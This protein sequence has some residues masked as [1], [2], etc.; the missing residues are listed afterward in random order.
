MVI[1]NSQPISDSSQDSVCGIK[2]RIG[3]AIIVSHDRDFLNGLVSKVYEFGGGKVTEHLGG[4]YDFLAKKRLENLQQLELSAS[5]AAKAE[6][7]QEQPSENKLSYQEQ[8]EL[9]KKQ[10][11]LEKQ[12]EEA[13]EKID[14]LE[15]KI[16]GMEAVLSTPEGASDMDMLQKYVETK[17][18]LDRAMQRWEQLQDEL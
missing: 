9:N 3:T 2:E 8:K 12:I 16:S 10:R 13:E 11:K 5:A 18:L 15:K 7:K 14:A 6:K 17:S 4:I 1:I